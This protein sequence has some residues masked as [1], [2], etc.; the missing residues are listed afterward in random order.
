M[1]IDLIKGLAVTFKHIWKKPVTFNYPE[2]KRPQPAFYRGR[3]RL[4]RYANGLERCV[5]CALCAAVCPPEAIYL[6]AE[7]NDPKHPVGAGE[8]YARLYQINQIRCIWCG[9]CEEACP[10]DAI[11]MGPIFEMANYTR[12]DFVCNKEQMLDPPD[13]GFGEPI[14]LKVN[15]PL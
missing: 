1:L 12:G 14:A 4:Q 8:R 7:E 3:H 11:V 2:V 9:F 13:K 15:Q 10:E 6:E 5:A